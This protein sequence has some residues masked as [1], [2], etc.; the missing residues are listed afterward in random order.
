LSDIVDYP[1]PHHAGGFHEDNSLAVRR[2]LEECRGRPGVTLRMESGTYHF[3]PEHASERFCWISNNDSGLKRVAFLLDGFEGLTIDGQGAELV[4]HGGISPFVIAHSH[5]ITLRNLAVDWAESCVVEADVQAVEGQQV[6]LAVRP[7]CRYRIANGRLRM[8]AA[9]WETSTGGYI[10]LDP[11]TRGPAYRTGDCWAGEWMETFSEVSANCLRF[12]APAHRIPKMGNRLVFLRGDRNNPAVFITESHDICLEDVTLY[13]APAMGVIA[14]RSENLTLTRTHVMLRPGTDRLVSATADATHFV[15]C[16]G[17]IT[18]DACL[19]ENQLDDPTNVHGTYAQVLERLSS[20]ELLL[21]RMHAQ[22]RGVP[23]AGAGDVLQFAVPDTMNPLGASRIATLYEI[24]STDLCIVFDEPLPDTICAGCVAENAS[25][26]ADLT[27][28]NCTARHNR[29]RGFLISTPGKVLVEGCTLSPG[30]TGIL[31]PGESEFWFESGAVSDVTIQNN[32]FVDCCTS[33]WGP[34]CI[35][36]TPHIPRLAERARPF[37]RNITIQG[38][39]FE[40][41]DHAI[42]AAWSVDGLTIRDNE[43]IPTETY[44]PFGDQKTALDIRHSQ[45]VMISGNQGLE[46]ADGAFDPGSPFVR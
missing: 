25:W 39:T 46:F 34:A 24:N 9:D 1:N 40:T 3:Y 45:N 7:E 23:F 18:L 8:G 30:G 35:S 43:V 31:I 16:R 21:G 36:I 2:A 4:F 6:T 42:V 13:Q 38:N 14:Q 22:Q 12:T 20:T 5:G 41:F 15:G 26:G 27:I 32:R 17:Q 33:N 44:E 37:H 19:F 29:A 28:R 11:L 10:E